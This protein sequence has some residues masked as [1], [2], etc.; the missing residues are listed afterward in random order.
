MKLSHV[1]GLWTG[2]VPTLNP[3][4]PYLFSNPKWSDEKHVIC[5]AEKLLNRDVEI[6]GYPAIRITMPFED[7]DID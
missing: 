7:E 5:V 2:S 4:E 6:P 3:E 1:A